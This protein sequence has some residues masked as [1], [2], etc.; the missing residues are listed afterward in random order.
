M[1][2]R[3]V[4]GHKVEDE[5]QAAFTELLR[6]AASPC[7][8]PRWFID[9][10]APHAIGRADIVLR[11]KVRQGALEIFEEPRVVHGDRDPG[12]AALPHAHEPDGVKAEG[13]NLIPLLGRH[14]GEIHRL[15]GISD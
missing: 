2:R 13:G 6:A 3:D 11:R 4:V 5:P 15:S 7:G 1:I 10:V 14:R 8:P 9:D 12:R